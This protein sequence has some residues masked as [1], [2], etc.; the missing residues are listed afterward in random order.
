MLVQKPILSAGCC[1]WLWTAG[2]P[3]V[4]IKDLALAGKPSSRPSLLVNIEGN[5]TCSCSPLFTTNAVATVC[6]FSAEICK[7]EHENTSFT[8][9]SRLAPSSGN[10]SPTYMHM[11]RHCQRIKRGTSSAGISWCSLLIFHLHS[12]QGHTR[13]ATQLVFH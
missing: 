4:A 13:S 12:F 3:C 9:S 10:C 2:F 11:T 8:Y 1:W 6:P 5:Q 7:V